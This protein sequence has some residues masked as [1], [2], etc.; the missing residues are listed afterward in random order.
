MDAKSLE[1]SNA[2][3]TV[4]I[5]K[6]KT[7]SHNNDRESGLSPSQIAIEKKLRH[8]FD[9]RILPMGILIYLMAQIDRSNMSN[10]A[11]LG[12]R[13]DANLTGNRFN[14]ALTCFFV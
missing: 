2:E 14:V 3:M 13:Q 7:R 6:T 5:E 11:V 4:Q 9:R 1:K 10:A 12:I 8:K